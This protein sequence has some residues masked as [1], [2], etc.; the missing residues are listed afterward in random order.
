MRHTG[1][2]T[3]DIL[4]VA[5][6]MDRSYVDN[7]LANYFSYMCGITKTTLGRQSRKHKGSISCSEAW[8]QIN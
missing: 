3:L 1:H 2:H 7:K 4:D 8:V 6:L 5:E